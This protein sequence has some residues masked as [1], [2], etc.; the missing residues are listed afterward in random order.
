MPIF[1]L[2]PCCL[3]PPQEC[4]DVECSD[5]PSRYV[6]RGSH[7]ICVPDGVSR[8]FLGG[9][10]LTP[11]CLPPLDDLVISNQPFALRHLEYL[12]SVRKLTLDCVH[13][14][15]IGNLTRA[16]WNSVELCEISLYK[17]VGENEDEICMLL[18]TLRDKKLRR[19]ELCR[20]TIRSRNMFPIPGTCLER[21]VTD[22]VCANADTLLTLSLVRFYTLDVS[23]FLPR[24]VRLQKFHLYLVVPGSNGVLPHIPFSVRELTL[25]C[26]VPLTTAL[27]PLRYLHITLGL[28]LLPG[29]LPTSLEVFKMDS[30]DHVSE[31]GSYALRF[32][33]RLRV[34]GCSIAIFRDRVPPANP[35]FARNL[36]ASRLESLQWRWNHDMEDVIFP[37]TLRSLRL[38]TVKWSVIPANVSKVLPQLHTF[39]VTFHQAHCT[40]ELW[41]ALSAC[42]LLRKVELCFSGTDIDLLYRM[43]IPPPPNM[44]RLELSP[45]T[46]QPM[47]ETWVTNE[48]C[49]IHPSREPWKHPL[50]CI[51][52]V[53]AVHNIEYV[54]FLRWYVGWMIFAGGG[55]WMEW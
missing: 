38:D 51:P 32:C 19:L 50:C 41:R 46:P 18:N 35:E 44:E 13:R 15:E 23:Q 17:I 10:T 11:D 52:F 20:P 4:V 26:G 5:W 31:W 43:G 6:L 36:S 22:L 40:V 12:P 21:C 37:P 47:W 55:E 29:F 25:E 39:H 54:N 2:S 24:C 28:P 34:L 42:P 8:L 3:P 16:L 1:P 27:P 53:D 9:D 33:P 48:M 49:V 7:S 30:E 45:E 14:V